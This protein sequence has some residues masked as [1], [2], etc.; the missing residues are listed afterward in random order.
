MAA[1]PTRQPAFELTQGPIKVGVLVPESG[2]ALR[3]VVIDQ[4]YRLLDGSRFAS[5]RQA[6]QTV[7]R[8]ANFVDQAHS[9]H[10][11]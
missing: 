4:R 11:A 6:E 10:A 8:L 3:L 5:V 1:I 7:R 2:R 9:A